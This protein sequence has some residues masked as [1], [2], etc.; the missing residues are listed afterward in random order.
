MGGD[1]RLTKGR[2]IFTSIYLNMH[3]SITMDVYCLI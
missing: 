3:S 2:Q 1:I